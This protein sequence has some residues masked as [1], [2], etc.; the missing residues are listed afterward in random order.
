MKK[1]KFILLIFIAA[2]FCNG[3]CEYREGQRFIIRNNSDETIVVQFSTSIPVSQGPTCMK[4]P[5][6]FEYEEMIHQKAVF[7]NSAKNF[8]RNRL[9]EL[10]MSRP[11]D[12]LYIGVFYRA[13]IDVMSCEEF[14]QEFPLKKEW[15][16]TL[17][18]MEACDWTLVYTSEE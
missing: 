17:A 15:K 7:P 11:N 16:V 3:S 9:G 6:S 10:M 8:E 18:D 1:Y 2:L 13:D 5:T 4:P 14:E 12:T